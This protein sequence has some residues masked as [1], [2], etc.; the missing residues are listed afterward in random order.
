MIKNLGLFLFAFSLLTL[1]CSHDDAQD[2]NQ[3]IRALAQNDH[4]TIA[5][6]VS[7]FYELDSRMQDSIR[8]FFGGSNGSDF[9]H[10]L[11]NRIHYFITQDELNSIKDNSLHG[12]LGSSSPTNGSLDK[13]L[14]DAN[15]QVAA[16]N[17]GVVLWLTAAVE[18]ERNLHFSFRSQDLVLDNPRVGLMLIGEGY[19]LSIQK[20]DGSTY[21]FPAAYRQSILIHEARHSDCP[22]GL[23]QTDLQFIKSKSSLRELTESFT[24]M[25][26]GNLHSYCPESHEYKNLP[27]CDRM[28]WGAYS[29]GAMFAS[30]GAKSASTS[31]DRRV[32]ELVA[33]DQLS[34]VLI[35]TDKMFSGQLGQP[36]LNSRGVVDSN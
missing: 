28:T 14:K 31:I 36:E 9:Q 6:S 1:S 8:S 3:A 19:H 13:D 11:D 12:R 7:G 33:A 30:L 22:S 29:A 15:V 24:K 32:M 23:N 27:A 34:R 17:I 20:K 2:P 26:C 10:F 35:D 5:S 18:G 4:D 25:T 16:T 21:F